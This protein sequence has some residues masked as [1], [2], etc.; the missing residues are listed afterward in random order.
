[1]GSF[2]APAVDR[3]APLNASPQTRVR[4][5]DALGYQPRVE[6]GPSIVVRFLQDIGCV[7]DFPPI[8]FLRPRSGSLNKPNESA[9]HTGGAC[10]GRTGRPRTARAFL[11]DGRS[12]RESAAPVDLLQLVR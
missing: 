4:I 5:S 10:S 9:L 7:K 8:T 12:D 6:D 3:V 2:R 11:H 1:M